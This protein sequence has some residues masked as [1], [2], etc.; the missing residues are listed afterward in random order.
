MGVEGAG[1]CQFDTAW[2]EGGVRVLPTPG[3]FVLWHPVSLAFL[4]LP[5]LSGCCFLPSPFLPL[6]A[7]S[8][9]FPSS[10]TPWR[11]SAEDFQR[12]T[13]LTSRLQA[14][15]LRSGRGKAVVRRDQ[16]SQPS[17]APS[18]LWTL[19]ATLFFSDSVS[20]AVK[21]DSVVRMKRDTRHPKHSRNSVVMV[22]VDC[23]QPRGDFT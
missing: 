7:V 22:P 11:G 14:S 16:S 15:R 23:V 20:L 19:E 10:H 1:V 3:S 8:S 6:N 21:W 4:S 5:D 9:A 18:W 12:C 2:A 17:W 13:L